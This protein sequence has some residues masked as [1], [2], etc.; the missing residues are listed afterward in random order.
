MSNSPII[1]EL[2]TILSDT[3][4]KY[5]DGLVDITKVIVALAAAMISVIATL[6]PK[7]DASTSSSC[8]FL[9]GI[10]LLLLSGSL[11]LGL[12]HLY[13]A[14]YVYRIAQK[15]VATI[16]QETPDPQEALNKARI[17]KIDYPWIYRYIFQ[18]VAATFV[19]SVLLLTAYTLVNL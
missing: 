5:R 3:D 13:Q 11:I 1:T 2:K 4:K 16:I 18:M 7:T 14:I 15:K 8:V 9:L 12:V 17:V 6:A 19:S 10:S